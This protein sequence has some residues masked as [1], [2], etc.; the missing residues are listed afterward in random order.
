V[1]FPVGW[2]QNCSQQFSRRWF[3]IAKHKA[4]VAKKAKIFNS[5]YLS[6]HILTAVLQN[7]IRFA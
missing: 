4:I 6:L 7:N 5:K 3:F 2:S 1:L